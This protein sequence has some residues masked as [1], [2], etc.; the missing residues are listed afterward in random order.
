MLISR[1]NAFPMWTAPGPSSVVE[2]NDM[3]PPFASTFTDSDHTSPPIIS[4]TWSKPLGNN[5]VD[6]SNSLSVSMIVFTPIFFSLSIL[7]TDDVTATI[8]QC[9][10]L[11]SWMTKSPTPPVAPVTST[12][13]FF[14]TPARRIR[15]CA[16]VPAS[17]I[18]QAECTGIPSGNLKRLVTGTR[19]YS[20]Y[21]PQ[22]VRPIVP[23]AS[24]IC[25]LPFRHWLQEPQNIHGYT[26]T[27][28]PFLIRIL[29]SF[30][31]LCTVPTISEPST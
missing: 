4:I 17:V 9:R 18:A 28:S 11:R 27:K 23:P 7:C 13:L 19:T 26:T 6:C 30:S 20:A 8:V 1:A 22:I 29:E 14:L 24:H 31:I 16:V 3:T 25:S 21:P 2:Q 12:V 15:W 10:C 5:I